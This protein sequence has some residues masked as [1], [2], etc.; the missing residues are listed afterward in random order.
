M[1]PVR[2]ESGALPRPRS[3][4]AASRVEAGQPLS[5]RLHHSEHAVDATSRPADSRLCSTSPLHRRPRAAPS[6]MHF[7]HPTALTSPVRDGR[8]HRGEECVWVIS[9]NPYLTNARGF[10]EEALH[11]ARN[12]AA[13]CHRG[14]ST[15][16]QGRDAILG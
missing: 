4:K 12:S 15:H 1:R 8:D 6:R 7:S 16:G 3:G 5:L 11:F 9:C 10:P 14:L 2:I 13:N